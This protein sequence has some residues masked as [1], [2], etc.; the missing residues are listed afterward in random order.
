MTTCEC[1]VE[2]PPRLEGARGR[3]RTRCVTCRPPKNPESLESLAGS[4]ERVD[5][6]VPEG[7]ITEDHIRMVRSMG[8][9]MARKFPRE[10]DDLVG[11]G[12][13]GLTHAAR[14]FDGTRGVEFGAFAQQRVRGAMI[15]YI[16]LRFGRRPFETDEGRRYETK[17]TVGRV[18][19]AD[20][21]AFLFGFGSDAW[22]EDELPLDY[23]PAIEFCRQAL[24]GREFE[25]FTSFAT[26]ETLRQMADRWGVTES[27]VCQVRA[28][29][30]TRLRSLEAELRALDPRVLDSRAA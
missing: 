11:A 4:A 26:G 13:E 9:K 15:D 27:R 14:A 12:L 16:R 10:R 7:L 3:N 20:E 29:A 1:G 22:V 23:G 8:T 2:I 24:T 18:D 5:H 30:L 6:D 17:P 19:I 28:N 25:A 21:P